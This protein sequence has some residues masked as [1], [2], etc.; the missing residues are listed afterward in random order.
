MS[1]YSTMKSCLVA[2]LCLLALAGTA[3]ANGS[4]NF[5]AGIAASQRHAYGAAITFLTIALGEPDLP[6][7]LKAGALFERGFAYCETGQYND[8]IA[9]LTQAIG[10]DPDH[11]DSFRERAKAYAREGQSDQAIADETR[12]L[13]LKRNDASLY[14]ERALL[15]LGRNRWRE[16]I[17]DFSAAIGLAPQNADLPFLR[18][19]AFRLA[20]EPVRAVE[21]ESRALALDPGLVDAREERAAAYEDQGEFGRALDDYNAK[22]ARSDDTQVRFHIGIAEWYLGRYSD[23][24]ASF[25]EMLRRNP[26]DANSMLWLTLARVGSGD[27]SL[28]QLEQS[29]R[30]VDLRTWPGPIIAFYLQKSTLSQLLAIAQVGS[31]QRLALQRCDVNFYIGEWEIR[32]NPAMAKALFRQSAVACPPNL[33]V[34]RAAA[35]ELARMH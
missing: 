17:A 14:S 5:N 30:P 10:L 4:S 6:A 21:D 32:G 28:N 35:F 9:D 34:R 12:A 27:R 15:Y 19:H 26:S 18:G 1:R 3:R 24:A 31:P 20:G 22:L 25:A 2:G 11:A 8:A 29:A 13:R 33:V 16:T 23:A 7:R